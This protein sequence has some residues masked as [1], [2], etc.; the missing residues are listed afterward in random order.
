[1]RKGLILGSSLAVVGVG[2]GVL[3]L[4]TPARSQLAK[5]LVWLQPTTPGSV[6]TGHL[7][8]SG[9]ARTGTTYTNSLRVG[10]SATNGHYLRT[11]ASGVGTW[12]AL[13][14]PLPY[15]GT[16]T[17]N[18]YE[19]LFRIRNNGTAASIFARNT[20]GANAR[21]AG[22]SY[23][24]QAQ[25]GTSFN[26]GQL[27]NSDNAVSGSNNFNPSYGYLAGASIGCYGEQGST[28]GVGVRGRVYATTGANY[29]VHGTSNSPGGA[30]VFGLNQSASSGAIGVLGQATS[31]SSGFGI[32]GE[33]SQYGIFAMATNNT[34]VPYGGW[35][36]GS[37]S[38]SRGAFAVGGGTN[39][40]YGFRGNSSTSTG[41]AETFGIYSL[42]NVGAA[43]SK[44]FR[45][46]HPHDPMNK[47]LL[48]YC[49]EGP[50]P[51]NQYSGIVTTDSSGYAWV[52]LP[53]YFGDINRNPRY[54][55]TVIDD[56]DDFVLAKVTRQVEDN[57]FRIRTNKPATQ[58]S[59]LVIAERSDRWMQAHPA[60]DQVEKFGDERGR[61]QRPELYGLPPEMGI[62]SDL[63]VQK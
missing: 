22:D 42:N 41:G 4:S 61:L 3:S 5:A 52:E 57:R 18:G 1:M 40:T 55:L 15:D 19:G 8:I 26:T 53:A 9:T 14:I 32:Y 39:S 36:Q 33:G 23:G 13:T 48:H 59:W 34:S 7:N 49:A 62:E 58:V 43:G 25:H 24:V 29:G 45:I 11:D 6:Q 2:I 31:S 21:L 28:T 12:Q 51:M 10:S 54:V 27:G 60:R 20:S 44:S 30:G 56:S 16:G 37:G 35:F 17:E 47:Y 38:N 46:D 63:P 50:A